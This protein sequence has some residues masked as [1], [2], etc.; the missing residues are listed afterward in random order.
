MRADQEA[1]ARKLARLDAKR[2]KRM[3]AEATRRSH[4]RFVRGI[5]ALG[6][7][8]PV[9]PDMPPTANGVVTRLFKKRA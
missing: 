7:T 1:I 3:E 2:E 4:G 5:E 6:S 8:A 9:L